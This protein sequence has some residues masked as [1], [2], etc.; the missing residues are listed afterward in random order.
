MATSNDLTR[1]EKRL[2]TF[3]HCLMGAVAG[4]PNDRRVAEKVT[5]MSLEWAQGEWK[6]IGP[7]LPKDMRQRLSKE[8]AA[9]KKAVKG[10]KR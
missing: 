4:L 7:T 10:M 3:I 5:Q 6:H 2:L 8:L 1:R 9:Y